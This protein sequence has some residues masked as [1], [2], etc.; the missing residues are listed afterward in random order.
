MLSVVD[1]I[2]KKEKI[3]PDTTYNNGVF[4]VPTIL[5]DPVLINKDNYTILVDYG[6]YTKEELGLE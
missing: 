1:K 2:E 3:E 4:E 5:Y 6:F